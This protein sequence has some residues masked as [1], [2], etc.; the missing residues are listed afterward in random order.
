M[1]KVG[2]APAADIQL[3]RPE[4]PLSTEAV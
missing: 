1:L 4:W 3:V 2:S